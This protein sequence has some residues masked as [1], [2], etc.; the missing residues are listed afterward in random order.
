MSGRATWD[1]LNS[2]A[3]AQEALRRAEVNATFTIPSL[4]YEE[5]LAKDTEDASPDNQSLGA[6]LV[7]HLATRLMLAMFAPSRP[8]TRLDPKLP[9][10]DAAQQAGMSEADLREMLATGER[11]MTKV[12][13]R[14]AMRPKLF[15]LLKQLIVVGPTM[16]VMDRERKKLRVLT[17]RR[18]RVKRD[19]YGDV[20]TAVI[21]EELPADEL[22]PNLRPPTLRPTDSKV[23]YY[24]LIQ[25]D[26]AAEKYK[27]THWVD[28]TELP[29]LA[30]TFSPEK[31]PYRVLT[32]TLPDNADY[33]NSL[34]TEY[35][36][37]FA[38]FDQ[39][40]GALQRAGVLASEYRW[41]KDP[42]SS[43]DSKDFEDSTNGE[44]V[45]GEKGGLTIVNVAAEM[46]AAMQAQAL[47]LKPVEQRLARGFV[48]TSAVVRDS[49][50]TTAEEVRALAAELDTGLGGGYSRL[51]VD[52]QLPL[53]TFLLDMLGVS[54]RPKDIELT[55]VTGLDA[56]SRHGDLAAL[57]EWLA[58]ISIVHQAPPQVLQT[59]DVRA[60]ALDLASPR[61]V[62]ASKYLLP[63]EQVKK[64]LDEQAQREAAARGQQQ[65]GP[66]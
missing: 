31:L 66:Q 25:K 8:F 29:N 59:L 2:V 36:G 63:P 6:Q 24:V 15:E 19:I 1:K 65:Q 32:W 4:F 52:V 51:A 35:G 45:S 53:A 41:L 48:M 10:R 16:L 58:D 64:N 20:H 47:A 12:L 17:L 44:V 28:D 55:I 11:E 5:G 3:G 7:N 54:F 27:V 56:L 13:D 21:K 39:L 50:R 18:F 23:G 40:H 34:V 14:H 9:L 38:S 30:A 62:Q 49:E 22:P 46:A 60:L 33:G 43:M 57:R 61:G 42:A 26:Y 37:D